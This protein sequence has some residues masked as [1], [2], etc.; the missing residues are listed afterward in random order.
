MRF[1]GWN[2]VLSA[3]L[4][5]SAFALTQTVESVALTWIA[6]I[7]LSA[8][9]IASRG[10]PGLRVVLGVFGLVLVVAA[11]FMTEASGA[12][13]MSHALVGA[14]AAASAAVGSPATR[15]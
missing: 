15:A 9:A 10:R 2:L 11:I 1:I 12:A 14:L 7:I 4:T 6:A 5:I 8:L 3:W 13:R